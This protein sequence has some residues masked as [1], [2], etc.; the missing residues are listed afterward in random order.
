[1]RWCTPPF[2]SRSRLTVCRSS[3]G[4]KSYRSRNA[5]T[6]PRTFCWKTIRLGAPWCFVR[7]AKRC[8][9]KRKDIFP[10]PLAIIDAVHKGYSD[11]LAAGYAEEARRFGDLAVSNVSRQLVYLFFATTALKRDT[12]LPA[13][14]SAIAHPINKLGILGAGFMGAGIASIA[15]Q[16]GTM[17][18]MKDASYERIAK[19][20]AAVREV[21]RE[22]LRKRQITRTQSEDMLSLA[23]TTI[24]YSGFANTDLVIEAVFEDIKVKRAVLTEVEAAAPNAIF[25]T[26]TST[27][28]IAD[29]ASVATHPDR[30]I[31][32][33]FFSP[34][35]KMPLLEVIVTPWTSAET[36]VTAVEYGRKLGKTVIVVHDGPGFYVNRIL[37]PYINECGKLLDDGASIESVDAAMTDFGFPVGG[38]TL[39][40]EVGLDIAGKSGAIL[41]H[42]FGDRMAPSITLQR[43]IES[44][45]LGRKAGKGFYGYDTQGEA[46]AR[47]FVRVRIFS[48]RNGAQGIRSPHN[49]ESRGVA[50]LERG[51]A[52]S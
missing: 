51:G 3:R 18:R 46:H 52:L 7:H 6:G 4:A 35:N 40:D 25:A 2:S 41:S 8:S 44:G 1:M 47:R 36:T 42:A 39:L 21:V 19:G 49:A 26:N 31:G 37:A 22:R 24:D 13:G 43:I 34:V 32:M 48:R 15:V 33:H 12:G 20:F 5:N 27:I 10:A 28:P 17:I 16:H 30:V 38:I 14:V 11:G 29:I 45:R 23:G 9:K 50:T